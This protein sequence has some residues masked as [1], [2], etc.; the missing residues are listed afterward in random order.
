MKPRLGCKSLSVIL[1]PPAMQES[2]HSVFLL[3]FDPLVTVNTQNTE[4]RLKVFQQNIIVIKLCDS[5]QWVFSPILVLWQLKSCCSWNKFPHRIGQALKIVEGT[6]A[7]LTSTDNSMSP[8]ATHQAPPLSS[9]Y[10]P[11]HHLPSLILYSSV[12]SYMGY[13]TRDSFYVLKP[14]KVVKLI[15]SMLLT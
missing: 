6:S 11:R 13:Q 12:I 9:A 3:S 14:K 2:L 8:Y 5:S 4:L 7:N 10:P 1:L 15:S